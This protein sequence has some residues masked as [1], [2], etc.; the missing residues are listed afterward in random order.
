MTQHV[1]TQDS[2]ADQ[3]LMMT[4]REL[5]FPHVLQSSPKDVAR[6][7]RSIKGSRGY[8][9]APGDD[10]ITILRRP[11]RP[12]TLINGNHRT[13]ALKTTAGFIDVEVEVLLTYRVPQGYPDWL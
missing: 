11:G 7:R 12:D 13:E 8:R 1:S 6:I 4:V 2:P 9:P 10:P 5:P 3:L